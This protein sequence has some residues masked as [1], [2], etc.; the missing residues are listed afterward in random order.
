MLAVFDLLRIAAGG[1]DQKPAVNHHQKADPSDY[2]QQVGQKPGDKAG[3]R[4]NRNTADGGI[5]SGVS[6]A[7][8]WRHI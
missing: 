4:I 6:V 3:G 8:D 2:C 5:Y 7:K 1:E